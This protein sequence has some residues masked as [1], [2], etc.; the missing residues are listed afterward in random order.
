[1]SF[2]YGKRYLILIYL[3]NYANKLAEGIPQWVLNSSTLVALKSFLFASQQMIFLYKIKPEIS[4]ACNFTKPFILLLLFYMYIFVAFFSLFWA[5]ANLWPFLFLFVVYQVSC[6]ARS[7]VGPQ[8]LQLLLPC[9]AKA[10][11]NDY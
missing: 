1:M 8:Q 6:V 4:Q 2:R 7:F 9:D 10:I 11:C 5:V 3:Q